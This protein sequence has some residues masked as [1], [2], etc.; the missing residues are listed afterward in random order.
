MSEE[1]LM[2]KPGTNR[3]KH[4]LMM[5]GFW[6]DEFETASCRELSGYIRLTQ[7]IRAAEQRAKARARADEVENGETRRKWAEGM[8]WCQRM[9]IEDIQAKYDEKF[10]KRHGQSLS[11]AET[12]G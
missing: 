6:R 12:E 3:Q 4:A 5:L 10:R 11:D 2:D 8:D 9:M 1:V 7:Q